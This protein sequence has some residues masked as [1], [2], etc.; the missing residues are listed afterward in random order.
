MVKSKET[1]FELPIQS[2][3][4]LKIFALETLIVS[5]YA[6]DIEFYL[7]IQSPYMVVIS[8]QNM[9]VP[10]LKLSENL[11]EIEK[12]MLNN[13]TLP[14]ESSFKFYSPTKSIYFDEIVIIIIIFYYFF[15]GGGGGDFFFW[16]GGGIVS[17]KYISS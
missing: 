1:S 2:V 16:G 17:K 11:K 6:M 5:H 3:E 14:F 12:G 15:V 10:R 7:H 13:E 8:T 4:N 9:R